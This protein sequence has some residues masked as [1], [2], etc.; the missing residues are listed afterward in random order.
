MVDALKPCEAPLL[1][2]VLVLVVWVVEYPLERV[3]ERPVV[4][5]TDIAWLRAV[6]SLCPVVCP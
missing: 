4:V 5:F 1:C 6:L 3:R 2:E